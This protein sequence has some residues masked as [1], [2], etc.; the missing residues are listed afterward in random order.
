MFKSYS[1][2]GED[3]LIQDVLARLGV[4]EGVYI[5]VG[6]STPIDDNN[7]YALYER[8][9]SGVYIEPQPQ[10]AIEHRQVR[11]RDVFIAALAGSRFGIETPPAARSR[12]GGRRLAPLRIRTRAIA[13]RMIA[14]RWKCQWSRWML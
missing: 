3:R 1:S 14:A 9:F 10:H 5:D 8:G 2:N 6:A 7:T 11:P 13:T 12:R 4:Q